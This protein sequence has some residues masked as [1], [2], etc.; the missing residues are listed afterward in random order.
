[1]YACSTSLIFL[2]AIVFIVCKLEYKNF[3]L[4]LA[5]FRGPCELPFV[6]RSKISIKQYFISCDTKPY[7]TSPYFTTPLYPSSFPNFIVECFFVW[8]LSML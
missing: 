2:K 7:L 1:M 5:I 3:R 8:S 4:H 6:K